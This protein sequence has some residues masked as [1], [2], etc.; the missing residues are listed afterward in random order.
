MTPV[1]ERAARALMF[2]ALAILTGLAWAWLSPMNMVPT[3]VLS[4]APPAHLAPWT[5]STALFMF[6]MWSVMMAGMMIPSA[7]PMFFAVERIARHRRDGGPL[8]VTAAFVLAYVAVWTGFSAAATAAQWALERAGLMSNAMASANVWLT[9]FVLVAAGLYQFSALKYAC[10]TRCRTPMG[11]LLTEWRPGVRGVFVTGLH[12]GI[13]CVGCCWALMALL[14]VFGT[15]NLAAAAGLAAL[16]LAEKALPGGSAIAR[17]L[18]V[19]LAGW[20]FWI[21][22]HAFA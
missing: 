19:A 7:A 17:V 15:M 13:H 22:I 6:V 8:G 9:G 14:F 1:P 16:V 3:G 20:G 10:L 2:A 5:A 4:R 18:G 11:F 12:H 21:L